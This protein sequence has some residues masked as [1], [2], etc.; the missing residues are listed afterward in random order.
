M[1]SETSLDILTEAVKSALQGK[2]IISV[3][4]QNLNRAYALSRQDSPVAGRTAPFGRYQVHVLAQ[5]DG[6]KAT[7]MFTDYGVNGK[8]ASTS[9]IAVMLDN[10]TDLASQIGQF[11]TTGRRVA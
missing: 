7:A 11:L 6:V 1:N 8:G 4:K 9:R 10:F 3:T 5:Q 2:A